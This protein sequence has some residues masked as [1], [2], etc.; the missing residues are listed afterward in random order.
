MNLLQ[1]LSSDR[2]VD[3]GR[4][5]K[6]RYLIIRKIGFAAYFFF[7]SQPSFLF[8]GNDG[9]GILTRYPEAVPTTELYIE[10]TITPVEENSFSGESPAGLYP[11]TLSDAGLVQMHL[12]RIQTRFCGSRS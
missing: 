9:P 3:H 5:R 11:F 10:G 12:S 1:L 8:V 2:D 6:V 4:L 7:N